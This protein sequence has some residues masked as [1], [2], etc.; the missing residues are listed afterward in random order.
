MNKEF[1]SLGNINSDGRPIFGFSAQD[2]IK[3]VLDSSPEAMLV[4]AH[5]WTPW[6]SISS[7]QSPASIQ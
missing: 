1:D 6:F 4:P 2:L 5:A 3:I 7:A